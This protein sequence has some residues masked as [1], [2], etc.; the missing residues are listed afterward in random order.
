MAITWSSSFNP[1]KVRQ[2][3]QPSCLIVVLGNHYMHRMRIISPPSPKHM[4]D[5]VL[6]KSTEIRKDYEPNLLRVS[7]S[8]CMS[9]SL[10]YILI[11]V[12]L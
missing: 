9:S 2:Q 6:T 5:R 1:F 11:Y 12:T 3:S 8:K 7:F 10:K 4:Q